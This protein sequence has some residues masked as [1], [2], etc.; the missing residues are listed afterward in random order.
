MAYAA[1][2]EARER[3]RAT[4]AL[5]EQFE[6][7]GAATCGK[8][9]RAA[10]AAPTC[11]GTALGSSSIS[12]WVESEDEPLNAVSSVYPGSE[13]YGAE[14]GQSSD[15]LDAES[16]HQTTHRPAYGCSK[17]ETTT[18]TA[19]LQ[20]H[21]PPGWRVGVDPRWGVSYY[22]HEDSGASQWEHPGTAK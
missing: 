1:M 14:L 16:A 11:E 21:L 8:R 4:Q 18:G 13:A 15:T 9:T 5:Y 12:A 7:D 2:K 20:Q 17:A 22:Y 19:H 6:R 3:G 10:E